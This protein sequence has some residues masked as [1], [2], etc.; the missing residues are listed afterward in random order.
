MN[1]SNKE[2]FPESL[3]IL[4]GDMIINLGRQSIVWFIKSTPRK[5]N[6]HHILG[7]VVDAIRIDSEKN[8]TTPDVFQLSLLKRIKTT[9]EDK[10]G[11]KHVSKKRYYKLVRMPRTA[12]TNMLIPA[13]HSLDS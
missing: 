13:A 11:T 2:V 3:N 7:W 10:D 1:R 9:T 6:G 12:P 5:I 8:S 4:P